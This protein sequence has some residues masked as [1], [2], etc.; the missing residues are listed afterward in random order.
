[1][2]KT[3]LYAMASASLL[4]T[5]SCN[6]EWNA[7]ASG[8]GRFNPVVSLNASPANSAD[9][10]AP[11]RGTAK[12]IG[13]NDLALRLTATATGV[14]QEWSSVSEFDPAKEF[15]VGPYTLEAY[16]GDVKE[17]GFELPHYY[18]KTQFNIR[19]NETTP[20]A[21]EARLANSMLSM[22]FT[23]EFTGYFT[24]Y[25]ID[26][27]SAGGTTT[28]WAPGENRPVYGAPGAWTVTA[29]VTKPTGVKA[30]YT[31]LTFNAEACHHYHLTLNVNEGNVGSAQ[32]VL[33]FDD[34][35]DKEDVII[36]LTQDLQ[37]TPA[38]VVKAEGFALDPITIVVGTTPEEQLR[39]MIT[40]HGGIASATLTTAS[41]SLTEQ[42]WPATVNLVAPGEA[43]AA[44]TALGFK[45]MGLWKNPDR[46]AVAELTNVVANI[47]YIEGSDNLS[48]FSLAVTDRFG[49]ATEPVELK[50]IVEKLRVAL[51]NPGVIFEGGTELELEM[52][53][54]GANPEDVVFQAYQSS[55][56]V[57]K[58]VASEI[59]GVKGRASNVY[60]VRLSGLPD[61]GEPLKIRAYAGDQAAETS[62]EVPRTPTAFAI[63]MNA[64]D[65]F[66]TRA[67]LTVVAN[68]DITDAELASIAAGCKVYMASNGG[69]AEPYA[70]TAS[71]VNLL[72]EGLQPGTAYEAYINYAGINSNRLQLA[73]EAAAQLPN[74]GMED[75]YSVKGSNHWSTWYPMSQGY[76]G[77]GWSSYNPVTV[78]QGTTGTT[79]YRYKANSGTISTNDAA[80]GS[81]AALVRTVGWGSNN[82]AAAISGFGTCKYVDAGQL[83]LGNWDGVSAVKNAVP[84]YGMS[85]GSRP[86]SLSFMYKYSTVKAGNGDY[87][88]AAITVY[89][90]TGAVIAAA[91]MQIN[92]NGTYS[93]MT[94]PLN[95]SAGCNKAGKISVIFKS[96]G[97]EAALTANATYMTP[98][99]A[100]NLSTGEYVGSQLYIDDI[101]LNY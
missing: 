47:R 79:S 100:R 90:T 22:T 91:D 86:A 33:S 49:R 5:T 69:K 14:A 63:A 37:N 89:D 55:T 78:S 83:F 98:P 35:M 96:S 25:S 11:S 41:T 53:Y 94:L 64:N 65:V 97:N 6:E 99:P 13:V 12:E 39:Y 1:M 24:D 26:V 52:E 60:M 66:A 75:W 17:E 73:T 95:Y 74:A 70:S 31:A 57:Y 50:V 46:L 10:K 16:Y 42:G 21:L 81:T 8:E 27:T 58:T 32:L 59:L 44:M 9:R 71:G 30:S 85:F 62:I 88:T 101:T 80:A 40:A 67:T 38:P 4:A 48:T 92:E 45:E 34:E 68:G 36:D 61:N 28:T 87:A 77:E 23:D 19:E 84:N 72:V 20:V 51:S 3:I 56:A 43:Q 29:N 2:K 18:G 93:K 7:G 76:S 82:T 15:N 54:N